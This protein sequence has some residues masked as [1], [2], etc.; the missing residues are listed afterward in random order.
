LRRGD[1]KNLMGVESRD[2]YSQEPKPRRALSLSRTGGVLIVVGVIAGLLLAGVL[3]AKTKGSAAN[4]GGEQSS[5]QG[6]T[7]IS[8]LPG[9][10]G[11]SIGGDRL[12]AKNDPWLGY[13]ADDQTCP[14]G[15]KLDAPLDD[16]A[17]TMVCLVNYARDRRGL[18]PVA[19]V[20][21][22]NQSS[23]A[24][25]HRIVRCLDFN[26]N[27]CGQAPEADIRA[28]GFNG[29]W[30]ENLFISGGAYGAPRPALDGWLN[31]PDHRENLFRPE[32]LTQGIAV[33]KVKNFGQDRNMTLWV[34]QFGG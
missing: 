9:L 23:L 16:Q 14:G 31:S 3:Q 8:L 12:Y 7:K 19:T 15:E 5:H 22:L 1:E 10:P 26:H 13:L 2:W 30:G 21:V 27:A 4:Y 25:A 11:I 29:A 34:N 6:A 20:D 28:L 17:N 18:Q 33:E 24:K 32:W